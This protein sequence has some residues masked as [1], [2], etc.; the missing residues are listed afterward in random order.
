VASR[1]AR[2]G[3]RLGIAALALVL[4]S[5]AA[6]SRADAP[7]AK[8]CTPAP[9]SAGRRLGLVLAGGGAKGAYEAGVAAAL[10]AR[11]IPLRL[12]AGSSAGA[13][14]AAM[15]ADGRLDRLEALWRALTTEQVY[16]PRPF[17]VL[18]GLLPG[19]LTLL[20][21]QQAGSIYDPA[22][23]RDLLEA[24]VDLD[25]IRAS[26]VRLA[27]IT[28]DLAR[29]QRRIFDNR[30][31]TL[32]ALMAAVA[33]P[34][35]FPPV[36]VGGDLLVDGGVIGRAPVIEA[37]EQDV[38]VDR[39]LVVLSYAPDER[40]APPRTLRRTLEESME[41]SMIHQIHRD[42][43]LARLKFPSVDVQV[44]APREPLRLRPL[45]FDTAGMIRVFEQGKAD[46]LACIDAWE[47]Q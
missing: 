4:A 31:V 2:R 39:V 40:G 25:R 42:I 11:R 10:A 9:P 1:R 18:S 47:G 20:A 14:N 13:L 5:L 17:V 21:V 23:L 41:M 43:E 38:P 7:A 37:L 29:R 19:W 22:P 15:I 35:V 6:S 45:E 26:P 12:V 16:F 3:R 34:G 28:T 46:G 36:K 32:D 8:G 30:T 33:V 44:L 24:T 27:I